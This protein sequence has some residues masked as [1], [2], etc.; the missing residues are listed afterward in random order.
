ML[1]FAIIFLISAVM[2]A[3]D[4]IQ[5]E[6]TG[7]VYYSINPRLPATEWATKTA[8]PELFNQKLSSLWLQSY[9]PGSLALVCFYFYRRFSD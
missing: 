5:A 2:N 7:V 1:F 6:R 8:E 3:K 9:F 4:A